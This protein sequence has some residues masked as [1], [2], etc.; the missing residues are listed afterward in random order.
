V[1]E[2]L[3]DKPE[4][5]EKDTFN[6]WVCDE[7]FTF[8]KLVNHLRNGHTEL[9]KR[10]EYTKQTTKERQERDGKGKHGKPAQGGSRLVQGE[11]SLSREASRDGEDGLLGISNCDI[12]RAPEEVLN[13]GVGDQPALPDLPKPKPKGDLQHPKAVSAASIASL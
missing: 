9:E 2:E 6:C 8:N 13:P 1:S 3:E 12:P 10:I 5:E 4:K 11:G 7:P